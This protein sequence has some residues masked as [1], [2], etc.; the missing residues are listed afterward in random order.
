MP[1]DP[2]INPLEENNYHSLNAW[3]DEMKSHS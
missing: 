1:I 2:F 3:C